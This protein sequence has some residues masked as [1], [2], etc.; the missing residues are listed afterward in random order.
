M[1][2]IVA[3]DDSK[4]ICALIKTALEKDGHRVRVFYDTA[5]L[6]ASVCTGAD[7]I[8]LDVMM[9][10]EDGFSACRRIRSQTGCPII[11]LTAKTDEDDIVSG[12]GAGGDDYI[13]KP[14]KI[15]VLRARVTA[16]LRRQGRTAVYRLSFGDISFDLSGREL[17]VE[18]KKIL[19]TK[20]EYDICE[21]L[22]RHQGL[23]YTREQLIEAVFG[24]DSESDET[25][26]TQHIKNIR[27]KLAE[28][29]A[30]PIET[31]WG[32]GYKWKAEKQ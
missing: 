16:H 4:E 27:A 9:P 1:A 6:D 31:V 19:L 2:N 22:A 20:G 11:F 28:A 12:L 8:L 26:I 18:D 7:L 17:Y 21:T 13:T 29:G 14:F 25:A 5:R 30:A 32:M 23:T 24:F 15:K 3:V 10:N